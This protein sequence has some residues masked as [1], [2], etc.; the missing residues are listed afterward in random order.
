MQACPHGGGLACSSDAAAD[1]GG[2]PSVQCSCGHV[3]PGT[4][5]T[6]ASAEQQPFIAELPPPVEPQWDAFSQGDFS[7]VPAIAGCW[8]LLMICST[9]GLPWHCPRKPPNLSHWQRNVFPEMGRYDG[10]VVGTSS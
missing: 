1:E 10:A 2:R 6:V 9:E 8:L 3:A 7:G 5:F 4:S